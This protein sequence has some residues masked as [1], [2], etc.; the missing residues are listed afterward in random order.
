MKQNADKTSNKPVT[1]ILWKVFS[2]RQS[3]GSPAPVR[4]LY[5]E[6]V[7][8]ERDESREVCSW[9]GEDDEEEVKNEVKG[10]EDG[11]L[12]LPVLLN[13]FRVFS[14]ESISGWLFG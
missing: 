7:D 1:P 6:E 5:A 13:W 11:G 12:L 8:C 14:N 4:E 2:G 10:L 9:A 3:G